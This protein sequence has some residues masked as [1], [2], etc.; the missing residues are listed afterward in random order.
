LQLLGPEKMTEQLERL[1]EQLA[2]FTSEIDG[3]EQP[4]RLRLDA[5][6]AVSSAGMLGFAELSTC[7]QALEQAIDA[8]EEIRPF[9]NSALTAREGALNRFRFLTKALNP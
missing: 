5:H 4:E 2:S 6:R 1:S 3:V 7:C 9:L 8:G